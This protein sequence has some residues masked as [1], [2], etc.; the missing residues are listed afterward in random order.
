[1]ISSG[2]S[3]SLST[4]VISFKYSGINCF[5]SFVHTS[6]FSTNKLT[7]STRDN[8]FS[9]SCVF[10]ALL[11]GFLAA[12]GKESSVLEV[13]LFVE[14]GSFRIVNFPFALCWLSFLT[15]I[16]SSIFN[17]GLATGFLLSLRLQLW[18]SLGR[19]FLLN[20]AT[21]LGYIQ[22]CIIHSISLQVFITVTI[23]LES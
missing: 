1:M 8:K 23:Q 18:S 15:G 13:P 2:C 3:L 7:E 4:V 5:S 10:N 22:R 11:F 9:R 14:F 20:C 19:T 16:Y 6:S 21:S 17:A 12:A